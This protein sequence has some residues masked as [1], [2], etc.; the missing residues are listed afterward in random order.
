MVPMVVLFLLMQ[1][2]IVGGL[3]SGAVK[4]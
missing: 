4:G 3:V 1:R 2:Y